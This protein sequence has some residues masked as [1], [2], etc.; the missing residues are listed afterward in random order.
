MLL[1]III[2]NRKEM[3]ILKKKLTSLTLHM[4]EQERNSHL[5]TIESK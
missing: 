4:R 3:E 2:D 1:Q 5:E